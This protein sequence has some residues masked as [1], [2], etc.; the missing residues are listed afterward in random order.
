MRARVSAGIAI[1]LRP[2]FPT[3]WRYNI[4]NGRIR[5]I[6]ARIRLAPKKTK[7]TVKEFSRLR[8][9]KKANDNNA[10]TNHANA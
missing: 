6:A 3:F 4:P 9:G 8:M 2:A 1:Q 5:F 10:I 7:P